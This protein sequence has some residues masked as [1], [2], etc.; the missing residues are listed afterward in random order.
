MAV[1]LYAASYSGT[2]TSFELTKDRNGSY[3]FLQKQ[4]LNLGRRTPAWLTLDSSNGI[5]YVANEGLTSRNGS[6]LSYKTSKEG[7]LTQ[8]QELQTFWGPVD[9][10]L[11]NSVQTFSITEPG[12]FVVLESYTYTMDGPGPVPNRQEAPHP[13]QSIL[14][15]TG[16]FLLMPD[17]GADLVRVYK[18]DKT[19]NKL[20]AV[21]PLKATPGSGPRHGTF[22]KKPVGGH[23][24]FYLVTELTS[25]VTAYKVT[26]SDCGN[27]S[28]EEVGSL[29]TLKPGQ[30]IPPT[31]TGEGTGVGAEVAVTHD[32]KHV[33]VSNR[34][35]LTFNNASDSMTVY[36][37]SPRTGNLTFQQQFPAGGSFPRQF[38]L[39]KA[40]DLVAVGLQ[41]SGLVAVLSR[42]RRT[43]LFDRQ[44]ASVPVAGQVTCVVWDE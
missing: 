31:T 20:T 32:N 12:Q 6:L 10:T 9:I 25:Q 29:S 33:I 1:N 8:I 42:N 36:E 21:E 13:H 26:H 37:I 24:I 4:I 11:G 39:N 27:L 3:A 17:L 19:T 5:L 34:R 35:D 40:G 41:N 18:I 15:P 23:Y 30:P 28:F 38:A 44:V 16:S 14:D 2:L 22:S 43:G 7:N